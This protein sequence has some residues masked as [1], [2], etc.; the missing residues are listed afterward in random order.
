MAGSQLHEDY[1]REHAGHGGSD[2]S[3]GLLFAALFT[4]IG[5]WPLLDGR[6]VR[7]TALIVAALFAVVALLRP[8]LL[9]R[10]KQWWMRLSLLLARITNPIVTTLLYAIAITPTGVI[11]RMAGKDPLRLRRNPAARSYW[12]DRTP[13][14]PD[15]KGMTA[16]F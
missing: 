9:K 13:P 3:F 12:I 16:Q 1:K 11:R 6:P 7:T 8:S 14:G 10:P 5:L 15:P 4:V 2:R